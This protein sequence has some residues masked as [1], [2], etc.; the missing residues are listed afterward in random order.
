M[1][2]IILMC[3]QGMS[4]SMMVQKMSEEAKKIDYK[5]HIEACSVSEIDEVSKN[6]D[7][8]ILGPQVRFQLKKLQAKCDRIPMAVIDQTDYGMMNGKKVLEMARRMM[9]E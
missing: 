5:C 7:V 2:N 3:S 8:I 6:A 4:T 9:G 1:K